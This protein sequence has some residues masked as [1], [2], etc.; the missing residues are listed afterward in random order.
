ML[1]SSP[2]LP[3]YFL[4]VWFQAVKGVSAIDSGI[5]LLPMI[6][7]M[8]FA[9]ILSG[10]LISRIGY[11]T[12][13]ML[14][15]NC[16][17]AVGAG[18]LTMLEVDTPQA[19]WIGYQVVYGIGLGCTFQAPN[20]AAQTVL[21]TRDVPVGVSLMLFSQLLGGAIFISVGQNVLNNQL[22]QRLSGLPGFNPDLIKSEGATELIQKLPVAI[23]AQVL[24]AYNDSLRKVFQVALIMTC[25]C[26]F[27]SLAM[28]WR[29]VKKNL[30]KKDHGSASEAE[31]GKA[32]HN[33]AEKV[34]PD[35]RASSEK[36]DEDKR[37]ATDG[38]DSKA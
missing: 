3:V 14:C 4:P 33:P 25:L 12:P 8:V 13:F 27:G 16:I 36:G 2:S 11:Y 17:M 20:L 18:L 38:E 35:E 32:G 29:S 5:R 23:R 22:L 31:D 9:A 6:L 7:P 34:T 1:T 15:G 19:K 10:V 24:S 21:P 37:R 26:I 28:E 30:P